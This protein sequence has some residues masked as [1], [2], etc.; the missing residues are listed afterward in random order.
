MPVLP[1][2]AVKLEGASEEPL[3]L[4]EPALNFTRR[5]QLGRKISLSDYDGRPVVLFVAGSVN[6]TIVTDQLRRLEEVTPQLRGAGAEVLVFSSN[7][8]QQNKAF[9]DQ[10]GINNLILLDDEVDQEAIFTYQQPIPEGFANPLYVLDA[11]HVIASIDFDDDYLLSDDHVSSVLDILTR[12]GASAPAPVPTP[13][14]PTP[15][16]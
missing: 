14:A 12:P 6:N 15:A 4:G 8:Y 5:D 3:K 1:N 9:A 13:P 16:A 10:N 2:G 11:N 7:Y